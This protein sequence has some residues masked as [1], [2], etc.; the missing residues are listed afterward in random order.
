MSR[1]ALPGFAGALLLGPCPGRR[2]DTLDDAASQEVLTE[3]LSRLAGLGA[4]GLLSLVEAKELPGGIDGFAAAVHAAG[5][6]W[7]HLAIPDYGVPDTDFIAGWRKLD[8]ARRLREG[9]NWA[10]HCRAGLGRT[11]TIAALLLVE[12]GS[13]AAEAI[14][15]IRREHD[16][17][18]V[19]T[20]AQ[21]AFLI[22]QQQAALRAATTSGAS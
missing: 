6:E 12:N 8:L 21:E 5:L 17:A 20:E 1:L 18:A 14:A 19:E 10:I 16:A 15:R 2:K 7:T 4:T 22:A 9:E 13:G 11:G 3:D